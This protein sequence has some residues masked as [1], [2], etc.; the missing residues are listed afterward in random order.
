MRPAPGVA[1]HQR[2]LP[3]VKHVEDLEYFEGPL[4]SEFRSVS[5]EPYLYYW[6]DADESANRWLVLRVPERSLLQLKARQLTLHGIMTVQGQAAFH[7][8]DLGPDGDVVASSMVLLSELPSEY[9]PRNDSYLPANTES[10][11]KGVFSIFLE[12]KWDIDEIPAL[13]KD[14][15]HVYALCFATGEN[16]AAKVKD[17][18]WQGGFSAMHFW[19]ELRTRIPPDQRAG[20]RSVMYASPGFVQFSGQDNL[21][22]SVAIGVRNFIAHRKQLK[23]LRWNQLKALRQAKK[24]QESLDYDDGFEPE[25]AL[26]KEDSDYLL[27]TSKEIVELLGAVNWSRL[28][29]LI[30]TES[31]FKITKVVGSYLKRIENLAKYQDEGRAMIVAPD[32]ASALDE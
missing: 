22:R 23:E 28:Q 10:A 25:P 15:S 9:L 31:A 1:I 27:V 26:S 12:G 24:D 20:L 8:V 14:Y 2:F 6:C 32:D 7:I 16:S 4:L 18:P 17:R 13:L 19:H 21:L 3:E 29:G 30:P 5:G 11:E